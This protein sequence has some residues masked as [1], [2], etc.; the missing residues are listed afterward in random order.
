MKRTTI[1]AAAIVAAIGISAYLGFRPATENELSDLQLA[2]AEALTNDEYMPGAY[3]KHEG[4]CTLRVSGDAQLKAL[5]IS[6]VKANGDG[7]VEIDGKVDCETGGSFMCVYRDCIT[8]YQIIIGGL[9]PAPI[10]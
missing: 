4:T 3:I 8:L 9:Q 1:I 6:I 7:T 5:G 10:N 2:N